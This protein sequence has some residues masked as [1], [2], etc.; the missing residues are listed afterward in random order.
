M[1][2]YSEGLR[3]TQEKLKTSSE[4]QIKSKGTGER[5]KW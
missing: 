2:S 1:C 4:K 3:L 5:L